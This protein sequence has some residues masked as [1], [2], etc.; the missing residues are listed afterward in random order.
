MVFL[1]ALS[2]IVFVVVVWRNKGTK[3]TFT[4]C[5]IHKLVLPDNKFTAWYQDDYEENLVWL[6]CSRFFY[7]FLDNEKLKHTTDGENVY[8]TLIVLMI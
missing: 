7:G 2:N 3:R 5:L 6:S 4:V 8:T 1:F